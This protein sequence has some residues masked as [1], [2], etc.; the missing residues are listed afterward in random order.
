[1]CF[2]SLFQALQD[3]K[4]LY[5]EVADRIIASTDRLVPAAVIYCETPSI[6]FLRDLAASAKSEGQS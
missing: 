1:M 6:Q 4:R 5:P 3:F 2:V